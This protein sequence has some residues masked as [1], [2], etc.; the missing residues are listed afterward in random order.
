[1]Y[2]NACLFNAEIVTEN[3]KTPKITKKSNDIAERR[4]AKI[5]ERKQKHL[6]YIKARSKDIIK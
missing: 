4:N 1:M 3:V 5:Q 2:T 6:A